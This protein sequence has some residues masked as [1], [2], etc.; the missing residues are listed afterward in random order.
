VNSKS[1]SANSSMHF[2]RYTVF[3]I[4]SFVC[5]LYITMISVATSLRSGLWRSMGRV[6]PLHSKS[7]FSSIT[8]RSLM[9]HP[10]FDV[11]EDFQIKE[12]GLSGSILAHRKSG[13]QVSLR[14][15]ISCHIVTFL[16]FRS[17]LL[18]LLMITRFSE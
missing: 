9:N 18:S 3:R 17:F 13:A 12:Y 16:S 10:S 4:L 7:R 5:V 11:I 1:T 14:Y 2:G 15:N 8:E 6:K